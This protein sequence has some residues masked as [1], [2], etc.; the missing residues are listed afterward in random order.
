M[1]TKIHYL[2]IYFQ[3]MKVFVALVVLAAAVNG[4]LQNILK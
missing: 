1:Y 2:N 4:Y 3:I